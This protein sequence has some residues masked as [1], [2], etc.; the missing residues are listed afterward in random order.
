VNATVA[1][2][3]VVYA[4]AVALPATDL[5]RLALTG[6][7]ASIP[8]ALPATFTLSAAIS[9]QVL[10]RGG[11]LLTRL[12]A[13]HEAAAMDILCADRTGTLT[14][15]ALDIAEVAPMPDYDRE[16]VLSLAALASSQADEDP[17]DSAI[18]RAVPITPQHGVAMRLKRLVPFDP[19]T[20]MSE[21]LVVD[22]QGNKVRIIKGAFQA[23]A[24]AAEFPA[25][26]RGVATILPSA[27][28][29]S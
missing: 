8:V 22:R 1:V 16:G 3:T 18:R 4:Y 26:A 15:N 7:L 11:V 25:V 14:R 6:L 13:V 21:A 19:D 24:G 20:K 17:I 9:A 23:V 2:L 12:S 27:A 5:I 10:A 29:G 28:I